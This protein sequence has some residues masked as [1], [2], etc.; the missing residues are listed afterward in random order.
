MAA[1]ARKPVFFATPDKMRAWLEKNHKNAQELWVGFYKRDSGKRSVTW[2]ESVDAALCYGWIDGVR[3]SIDEISYVIRFTPRRPSSI[4]SAINIKRAAEL[5]KSGLMKPAGHKAF[6]Q[7][8]ERKSQIYAYEQ[9]DQAKFDVISDT[10]FKA[11][12][13]AWEFFQSQPRWY[14]RTSTY[15][16]MTAKKEETQQCRLAT[17]I[18]DSAQGRTIARLTRKK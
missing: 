11:N 12:R 4:W 7:R 10:K 18:E 17:L 14:K 8:S 3:K 13:Q 9:R 2:P 6:A 16:V 5:E 1:Q 15:W